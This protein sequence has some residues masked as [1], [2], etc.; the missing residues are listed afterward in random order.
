[1]VMDESRQFQIVGNGG[2]QKTGEEQQSIWRCWGSPVSAYVCVCAH[3]LS[4]VYPYFIWMCSHAVG[5]G[6]IPGQ[7]IGHFMSM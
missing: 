6:M 2:G 5:W 4:L 3:A 7:I 1:M